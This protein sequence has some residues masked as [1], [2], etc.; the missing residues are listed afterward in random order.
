[1][2]R[3]RSIQEQKGLAWIMGADGIIG[4]TVGLSEVSRAKADFSLTNITYVTKGVF[5]VL[6]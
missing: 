1:M 2:P 3:S 6:L 4:Q 5:V